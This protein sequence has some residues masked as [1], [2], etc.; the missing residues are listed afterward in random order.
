MIFSRQSQNPLAI[1]STD[2]IALQP[3]RARC[4]DG[5]TDWHQHQHSIGKREPSG[6]L[7]QFKPASEKTFPSRRWPLSD[8]Y[9][10]LVEDANSGQA[11]TPQNLS[12]REAIIKV[13]QEANGSM[14]YS[15]IADAIIARK[16]RTE[17]GA[18]PVKTVAAVISLSSP[19]FIRTGRGEYTLRTKEPE[20]SG[21]HACG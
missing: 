19:E 1:T 8:L 21:Y 12:W 9:L 16:L 15:D 2:K 5:R 18:T 7:V 11:D 13:L 3:M 6:L 10:C 14:H 17:V 20:Q 4:P